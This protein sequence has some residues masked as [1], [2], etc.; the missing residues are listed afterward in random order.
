MSALRA[1]VI[2]VTK[3]P[4]ALLPVDKNR[5][6]EQI[7]AWPHQELCFSYYNYSHPINIFTEE[8]EPLEADRKVLAQSLQS[9]LTG[10]S[11]WKDLA[12]SGMRAVG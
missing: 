5:L 2:V 3:T 4:K 9:R 7:S 10:D 8:E 6:I 1:N 12:S 11:R